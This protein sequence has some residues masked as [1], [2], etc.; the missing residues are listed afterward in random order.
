MK[1]I[2]FLTLAALCLST[3]WYIHETAKELL[4]DEALQK[5]FS[6]LRN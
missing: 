5:I 4:R 3:V 1:K 2:V 6:Q